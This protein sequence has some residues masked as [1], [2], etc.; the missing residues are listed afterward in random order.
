MLINLE[1]HGLS[2]LIAVLVMELLELEL[3]SGLLHLEVLLYDV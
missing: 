1:T 3:L 2:F